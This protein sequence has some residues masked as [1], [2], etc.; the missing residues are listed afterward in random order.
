MTPERQAR[1]FLAGLPAATR[2]AFMRDA[3]RID[4]GTFARRAFVTLGIT[5]EE[6]WHVDAELW[7]GAR[8]AEGDFRFGMVNVPPRSLKSEI[9]SVILAAFLLG[10][11]P[12]YKI[13][14]VSYSQ[15]L[16]DKFGAGTLKVMESDWY[17]EAFPKTVL[18][19]KA[20][21]ELRTT[22]GGSRFATSIGGAATG[23]GG[24]II[25]VDDPIKA[26]DAES[27]A[28]RNSTNEWIAS[29]LFSRLDDKRAGQVILVSQRLHQDD[30]CGRVLENGGW[31]I[32][33]IPAIATEDIDYALGHGRIYHRSTGEVLHETREPLKALNELKEQMGGRRFAA[34]YQQEPVPFDGA[35]FK[36]DWFKVAT[37]FQRRSSDRIVQVWDAANKDGDQNDYSAC[38]TA[39]IRRRD[40]HIID[41][42]RAR[43]PFPAL[44]RQVI[45]HAREYGTIKLVI[46]DAAAGTQLIQVLR[47][48]RP[49]GVPQPIAVKP[50]ASKIER[51]MP[52]ADRA[53]QGTIFLPAMAPWKED[54]VNELMAFPMGRHD[55]QVDA[56]SILASTVANDVG[57]RFGPGYSP[58]VPRDGD[59]GRDNADPDI[60][61]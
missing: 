31:E 49:P 50:T 18:T 45:A 46:E 9:F 54:F 43:L 7:F 55:D 19:K 14:C 2:V 23:R 4:F 26:G 37:E 32:L 22:R 42:Y 39:V 11:D 20:A 21:S 13:M 25:I 41:V 47:D 6:N 15:P 40:I 29:T 61:Y 52:A 58:G 3:T 59:S 60:R 38:I 17:R 5:L 34:Q 10:R 57:Y 28:I 51:A 24:D 8:I 53:E 27:E 48:E 12:G 44:K 16:A 33:S 30:P 1:E 36:R 35:F 56:L